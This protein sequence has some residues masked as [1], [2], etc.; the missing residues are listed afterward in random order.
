[1]SLNSR[2]AR[3][4]LPSG[5]FGAV[6]GQDQLEISHAR[7]ESSVPSI[8]SLQTFTAI[9]WRT[10][11]SGMSVRYTISFPA[12]LRSTPRPIAA[13]VPKKSEPGPHGLRT[14][15]VAQEACFVLKRSFYMEKSAWI[16]LV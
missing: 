4:H 11:M 15:S 2:G 10:V 14:T 3:L 6:I 1:S 16:F 7:T 9:A 5:K 12:F 8:A 13:Q